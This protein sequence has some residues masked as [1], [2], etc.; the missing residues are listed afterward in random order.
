MNSDKKKREGDQL[1]LRFNEGS[2]MRESLKRIAALNGRTLTAEILYRLERSLEQDSAVS[3]P[4]QA[5]DVMMSEIENLRMM[6]HGESNARQA[7]A[8]R[9]TELET[10]IANVNEAI[11]ALTYRGSSED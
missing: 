11:L 9:T 2:N 4:E 1:L 8:H 6:L 5:G 10:A 7:L 3:T